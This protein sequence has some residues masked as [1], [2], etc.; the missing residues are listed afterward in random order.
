MG[1]LDYSIAGSRLDLTAGVV[2][3]SAIHNV[4]KKPLI[5]ASIFLSLSLSL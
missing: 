3:C 5:A 2:R 4:L 1:L